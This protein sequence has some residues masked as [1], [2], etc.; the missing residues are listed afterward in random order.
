MRE[1]ATANLATLLARL[2]MRI[3]VPWKLPG[4][5]GVSGPFTTTV[6]GHP[7]KLQQHRRIDELCPVTDNTFFST[8]ALDQ[9]QHCDL[10]YGERAYSPGPELVAG[11]HWYV[12]HPFRLRHPPLDRS[13]DRAIAAI[14][15]GNILATTAIVISSLS[16]AY[17]HSE[18]LF[19]SQPKSSYTHQ[20]FS[21][22]SWFLRL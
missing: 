14:V 15:I 1:D 11:H 19:C 13:T 17:Y 20:T 18:S 16:G 21:L 5:H 9:L 8:R 12:N 2:R 4:E 3:S 22:S 7:W 6:S 10:P